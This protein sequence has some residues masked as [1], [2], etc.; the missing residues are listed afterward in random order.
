MNFFGSK[1]YV[2]EINHGYQKMKKQKKSES[3]A[4][5]KND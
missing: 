5:K 2:N 1:M 4:E 3:F